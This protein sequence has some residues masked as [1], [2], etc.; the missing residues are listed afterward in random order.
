M[1]GRR[2]M[3]DVSPLVWLLWHMARTEDVAINVVVAGSDQVLDAE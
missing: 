1:T 3:I 2:R